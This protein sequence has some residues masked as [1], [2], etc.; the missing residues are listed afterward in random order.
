MRFCF[1]RATKTVTSCSVLTPLPPYFW[2]RRSKY[3]IKNKLIEC[4]AQI[5]LNNSTFRLPLPFNRKTNK[6]SFK[7]YFDD[8][9]IKF[10]R[11]SPFVEIVTYVHV[12]KAWHLG[13]HYHDNILM[14][15]F[16]CQKTHTYIL[17]FGNTNKLN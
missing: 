10:P 2:S 6:K 8:V 13:F 15:K 7:L 5:F 17:H 4:L 9:F 11:N 16:F 14:S 1:T 12:L 3:I